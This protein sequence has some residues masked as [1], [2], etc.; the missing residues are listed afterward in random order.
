[1]HNI[2]SGDAKRF[3]LDRVD[4]YATSF[5]QAID[6]VE[7]EYNSA[8]RQARVK[9]YLNHLRISTLESEG[10]DE[11]AALSKAYKVIT[12]LSMQGPPSH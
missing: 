6:L 8:V 9:N 1:M 4:G 12:K 3:Y 7:K 10:L 5:Q 2:L 11:A